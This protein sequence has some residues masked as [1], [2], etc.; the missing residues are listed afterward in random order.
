M[1]LIEIVFYSTPLALAAMGEII[2]QKSGLLNIGLEGM[3][4]AGA[5]GGLVGTTMT[6][7]PWA[8]I[9]LGIIFAV[10]I[11]LIQSIFVIKLSLDQVL[12]GTAINLFALG[13]TSTFFRKQYGNSGAL[14]SLPKMSSW[15]GIDAIMVLS[16]F[17]VPVLFLLLNRTRWGLMIQA[18]GEYPEAAHAAGYSVARLRL[19][20]S[21]IAAI[22]AGLGGA[23]LCCGVAGSFTE[24]MSAGR[25][26]VAIALVTFGRWKPGWVWLAALFIGFC[27]ALQFKLQTLSLN[28]P[29]E[30]AL[31]LPYIAALLALIIVG[32]GS[33]TPIALALP[34]KEK[35]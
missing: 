24:N 21:V 14:T 7:S 12:A 15:Q 6:G 22:F 10:I 23:Y 35:S 25:G 34:F 19:Q 27:E 4:L 32:K 8:G 5:F 3:I 20:A 30:F 17:M 29:S 2:G 13:I 28:I 9:L 1:N 33:K 16:V 26:L 31:A 11:G 18:C